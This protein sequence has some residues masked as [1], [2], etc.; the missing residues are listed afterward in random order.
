METTFLTKTSVKYLHLFY[1][2]CLRMEMGNYQSGEV[3]VQL[4][5]NQ[6]RAACLIAYLRRERAACRAQPAAC[7]RSHRATP[8]PRCWPAA[9]CARH[10]VQIQ[11]GVAARPR[12]GGAV[13]VVQREDRRRPAAS[14]RTT[15]SLV[16]QRR[17]RL[18]SQTRTPHSRIACQSTLSSLG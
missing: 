10:S 11:P 16:S 17:S 14:V 3:C 18:G 7:P 9:A 12:W 4:T 15:E 13:D 8:T 1:S 2:I 5:R 6:Y